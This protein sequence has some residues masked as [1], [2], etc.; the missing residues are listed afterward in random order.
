MANL[1]LLKKD[2]RAEEVAAAMDG[3]MTLTISK[4]ARAEMVI[5][6]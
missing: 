3:K 1:R 4:G 6:C 2:E 5:S